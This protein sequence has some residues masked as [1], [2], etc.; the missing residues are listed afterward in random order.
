MSVKKIFS[1][2]E[3]SL[4]CNS[5][6]QIFVKIPFGSCNIMV[7]TVYLPPDCDISKY[8]SHSDTASTICDQFGNCD[9]L[10]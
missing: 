1:T 9:I 2:T 6:E 7:G 5:V 8:V 10:S 3:I 4:R